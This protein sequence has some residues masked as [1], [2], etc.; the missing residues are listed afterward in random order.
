MMISGDAFKEKKNKI[1]QY[2]V[3]VWE[4]QKTVGRF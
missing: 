1:N 4:V 2:G 3:S